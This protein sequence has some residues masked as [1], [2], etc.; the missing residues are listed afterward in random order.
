MGNRPGK[1]IRT[2]L[3]NAPV[4][5]PTQE[6][7]IITSRYAK[8]QGQAPLH[9]ALIHCA[10]DESGYLQLTD[11]AGAAHRVPF[12]SHAERL[13]LLTRLI[14]ERVP[15]AVGG[16][17]PGPADEV[18]LL[19]ANKALNGPYIELSW[20]APQQWIVREI[21]GDT[22]EW[23]AESDVARIADTSF[24]PGFLTASK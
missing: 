14:G 6:F 13:S 22:M 4:N 20:T 19:I 7:V 10:A 21:A 16:M 9:L 5:S 23:E 8:G 11:N 1:G 2:E 3:S 24:D 17:C 12:S 15:M 18:A